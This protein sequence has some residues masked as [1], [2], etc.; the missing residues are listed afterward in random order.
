MN[1]G[2]VRISPRWIY[3]LERNPALSQEYKM[4]IG[5]NAV[6][7]EV[8]ASIHGGWDFIVH[9]VD[10]LY[11]DKARDEL[12]F[13]FE[14]HQL[15]HVVT[16]QK[17]IW[18]SNIIESLCQE[19]KIPLIWCELF[20][21]GRII[22]DRIGLQY[23][24]QNEL[25][26]E[27][28]GE[29]TEP[30]LP[31]ATRWRQPEDV[32]AAQLYKL[33]NTSRDSDVVIV[34]GQT[35]FD[36]SLREYPDVCYEQWFDRLFTSNPNTKFIFKHHPSCETLSVRKY[37]NVHESLVNI[38]SLF[39]AFDRFAA[40]SSTTIF[41]GLIKGKKFVTGGYHFCSGNG[42]VLESPDVTNITEKLK[43]F[44]INAEAR[45][46]RLWFI[47][48]KYTI[49]LSSPKLVERIVKPSEEFFK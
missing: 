10:K 30:L 45:R 20:F 31:T 37:P 26:Y 16:C 34:L 2:F 5:Q 40:F 21:D 9:T 28:A 13:W 47:C 42:L 49:P 8:A 48:N 3:H 24:K 32:P 35:P 29:P 14:H 22:V 38:D 33:Y 46:R 12:K 7:D 25:R 27:S 18:Y 23:C 6:P 15:T 19:L 4:Y 17:L 11:A 43:A 1:I 39:N 36:M 44:N 41:E